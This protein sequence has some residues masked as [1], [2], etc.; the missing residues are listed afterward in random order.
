MANPQHW[1][2]EIFEIFKEQ[3]IS[4]VSYVPDAGHRN[5]IE[6]CQADPK[7]KAVV[8]T[9]EEEGVALAAGAYL[10]GK[11][12]ALL[13]QSSGVG[14]CINMLSLIK[15]CAFPFLTLITMR[16][17]WGEF[18]P[19]QLPMGQ[20]T[21]AVLEAA[22]VIVQRVSVAEEVRNTVE[23]AAKLAFNSSSPV[24]VLI[25]QNLLGTKTFGRKYQM[26][27]LTLKRREVVSQLL[28]ERGTLLVVSGLGAPS[29][30][31]AAVGNNPLDFPLWG[32]MGGAAIVGL[33]LALAQP[34]RKV[35]VITGDGEQL[36]GMGGLATI[37]VQRPPNLRLVVLDNEHYGE[38]GQ[39][40]THTAYGVN[41]AAVA[42]ACGFPYART[43]T[44]S[45]EVTQFRDEIHQRDELML[46][47]IKIAMTA[48]PLVLPSRDGTYLKHC[49]REALLGTEAMFD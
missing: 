20:G 3:N 37:A 7:I 27:E 43:L 15:T 39:Q 26:G 19:W 30:D 36:M 49:F 38:T 17:E 41:L 21:P 4:V 16:G 31:L 35:L 10:G 14:N 25:S 28:H 32:A 29:W 48:D 11:R 18:N 40:Q 22:G 8:L 44:T 24:A 34:A 12:A 5:L 13:M 1:S 2:D 46:A 9:T 42:S 33:G 6:L 45:A 47:V 23:A